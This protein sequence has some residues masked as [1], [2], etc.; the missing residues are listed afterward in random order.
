MT[1]FAHLRHDDAHGEPRPHFA[2]LRMG[3][4]AFAPT[5]RS[6]EPRRSAKSSQTVRLQWPQITTRAYRLAAPSLHAMLNRVNMNRKMRRIVRIAV[7]GDLRGV[8]RT[9]VSLLLARAAREQGEFA[10]LVDA[11]F[12]RP[13]LAKTLGVHVDDGRDPTVAAAGVETERPVWKP[14]LVDRAE[15][16][17]LLVP[18]LDSCRRSCRGRAIATLNGILTRVA[19]MFSI[20]II[21]TVPACEAGVGAV[22]ALRPD[23]LVVVQRSSHE[24]QSFCNLVTRETGLPVVGVVENFAQEL[25]AVV[26]GRRGLYVG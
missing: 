3:S 15:R 13:T 20:A 7:T 5:G 11:D 21:D 9:T 23:A 14:P 18:T 6:R 10:L 24:N 17:G 16:T 12:E 8:G 26:A 4:P 22:A 25:E 1:N 2:Q 19:G